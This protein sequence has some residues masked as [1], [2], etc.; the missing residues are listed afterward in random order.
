[1]AP[2]TSTHKFKPVLDRAE[3]VDLVVT[4]RTSGR[5]S[6]RIVWFVH[7]ERRIFLVPV[8]GTDSQWFK[9]VQANPEVRLRAGGQ[10]LAAIAK[11]I[12]DG[13]KVHGVVEKFRHK[14]G[15]GDV[16]R[17]YSKLDAAVEIPLA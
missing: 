5:S 6:S 9:N 2:A 8:Y 14:Y 12:T 13:D 16:K 4:G 7:D 1:M 11:P 15:A 3:E 10:E 17:Y